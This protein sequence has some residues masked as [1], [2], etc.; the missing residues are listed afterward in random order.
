MKCP[1]CGTVNPPGEDF[2]SN[3]GYYLDP[4]HNAGNA[5][6]VSNASPTVTSTVTS[7][8]L[9]GTSGNLRTLASGSRLQN[10][11]YLVEKV[12]GQGGMGA[13]ML[14][15]D[16]NVANKQVVIKELISD[17]TDPQKRQ[18]DVRN[19]KREVETV[20]QIDHPLV[21]NVTDNFQEGSRYFMVQEYVGG[22][23]LE[24]H[25]ER[26]NQPMPEHEVLNYASQLL[27]ILD[28]LEQ[29]TPPIVHRDIKPANI[30][31]GTK[32]KRAHLVDFGIARADEAK[33]AKKKQTSALGTP[34]YAPPEQ[35][36]GN[37]DIR[38][39]LYALAATLH[40]LLTNRDPRNYPPFAY[41]SAKSL[42]SKLSPEIDHILTRALTIDINKRYQNAAS[43]KQDID[44]ILLQNYGVGNTSSYTLGT[45][46]P[47][48]AV[49]GNTPTRT[50]TNQPR[51][52]QPAKPVQPQHPVTPIPISS[53]RP[54]PLPYPQQGYQQQSGYPQQQQA[55]MYANQPAQPRRRGGFNW[56]TGSFLLL[57]LVVLVIAA[58]IF[59]PSLLKG[60]TTTTG[61]TNGVP[62]ATPTL[63]SSIPANGIGVTQVNNESIGISNGSFSFDTGSSRASA[64]LMQQAA[65]KF[66]GGDTAAAQSLW[67]Q[68]FSQDTSNAEA[69]IYLE[70]QRV[71]ASGRPHITLVVATMLTGNNV[72]VGRD[73]LQG[74][75]VAQKEIND[76]NVLGNTR[77]VLLIAN[78][79]SATQT[80]ASTVSQQIVKAAKDDP[81]IVGVMGWP[82]SG[83]MLSSVSI[84]SQAQLPVVSQTASSDS[85]TN[86]SQYF[87]R[88]APSNMAQAKVGAQYAYSKLNGRNVA[89]FVDPSDSYSQSL[90]QDFQQ[91]FTALGGKIAVTE[92]YTRGKPDT[93]TSALDAALKNN[94]VP[95]LIYFSGYSND[96][97]TV[98][99]N[100]PNY[101]AFPNLKVMGGDAL[102]NL[103]G[104]PQSAR[105]GF[106]RL[107]FT[108]FAY[109]DEWSVFGYASKQP[110]F[111]K[112]YAN[113]YDPNKQPHD[114][115]YG[116]TRPSSHLMLAYDATYTL[117]TASKN[118]LAGGKSSIKPSD[119]QRALTQ[120]T[121]ANA[122]QGVSGRIAFGADSNPIDKA[123]VILSVSQ[124]GFIQMEQD[125][126]GTFLK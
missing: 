110:A 126:G 84:F 96:V 104:Y 68:A 86:L 63:S 67:Q 102:Y 111:F 7:V 120:I 108:S 20:A 48:S 75:Y 14:A 5:T 40:H 25:M 95:D 29:Q 12:L 9:S 1:N 3:C 30:I 50:A 10:G 2:C 26:V 31:I 119:L 113:T 65:T 56:V 44:N 122:V 123:V 118:A 124:Q 100:L 70:N 109:P 116:Y 85:L 114:S 69:L 22:E 83:Y 49:G 23:N 21:P 57:L 93:I 47:I 103:G 45:S 24:D 61:G 117:L 17:N 15:R 91:S 58:L 101:T 121:G 71:L 112:N 37:A 74:A 52:V 78:A 73:D 87:F 34:G 13:A 53:A 99:T 46:G 81:T 76:G 42:N 89:L 32:D 79:G 11:R 82:F 54:A 106:N 115:P 38:S 59:A 92:N 33:N 80:N 98:I 4:A 6:I 107:R 77:V 64:S 60:R 90:A 66:S 125:H 19:F 55:G 41:P 16:T 97:S 35:Y 94:P 36:Q 28:Y 43:M 88:V 8:P 18:E 62:T 27:D 105:A 72:G 39:D 51:P